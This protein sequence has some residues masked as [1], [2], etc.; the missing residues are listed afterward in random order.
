MIYVCP[1]CRRESHAWNCEQGKKW[2]AEI[3]AMRTQAERPTKAHTKLKEI[4]TVMLWSTVS[5]AVFI[6]AGIIGEYLWR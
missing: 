2:S 1:E 5:L 4:A 3:S 6:A